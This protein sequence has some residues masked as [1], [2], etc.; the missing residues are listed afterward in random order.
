MS[1]SRKTLLATLLACGSTF[2]IAQSAAPT[3]Q[4]P[5]PPPKAPEWTATDGNRD[6]YL[7]KEELIPFPGVIKQFE[8]ID[9]DRD[10]RISQEEYRVWFENDRNRK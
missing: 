3:K 6:G 4:D 1:M 9:T 10:G 8:E 7:T 2:A 5:N